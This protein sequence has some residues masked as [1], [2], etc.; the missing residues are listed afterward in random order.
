[1]FNSIK[2]RVPIKQIITSQIE[3]AILSKKYL[4]GSKLPTEN[5][6]CA[7]FNVSR[8]SVREAL[9]TLSAHGLIT[10]EKGKGI[11]VN[12]INS[13]SVTNPLAKY[14]KQHLDRHTVTDIVRARQ[15]IE[16]LIAQNAALNHTDKDIESLE[17]DILQMEKSTKGFNE[18]VELDMR[19]HYNL[20]LATKNQVIPLLL[21]VIQGLLPGLK[22]QVYANVDDAKEAA[23]IWHSKILDAV[24]QR[25]AELAYQSMVEHLEKAEEH[26]EQVLLLKETEDE[27]KN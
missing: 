14:L 19:F 22:S 3:D 15:M 12:R 11:F 23:I 24:K 7:Q 6:L 9:Q 5:E 27:I 4:P 25:N 17:N 26:A 2:D 8:T 13:E 21:K 16:P 20:S 1:M 10:V 18:L